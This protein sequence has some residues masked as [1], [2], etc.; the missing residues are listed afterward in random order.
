[1][2]Y[3]SALT[4][5]LVSLAACG[6]PSTPTPE[7]ISGDSEPPP[8]AADAAP[9]CAEVIDHV[10]AH[11]PELVGKADDDVRA[12]AV[13]QCEQE[14]WPDDL[15]RCAVAAREMEALVACL[16]KDQRGDEPDPSS[17]EAER[18]L[19]AIEKGA[20]SFFFEDSKFPVGSVTLSP[21]RSCCESADGKCPPDPAVW[22]QPIWEDLN[23]QIDEAHLY[24]YSYQSDGKTLL[25][26]AEADLDC[27]GV[28]STYRLEGAV[29]GGEPFFSFTLTRP[30]QAE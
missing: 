20:K 28:V 23:F 11:F 1:M 13:A 25:V 26:I 4:A 17:N 10:I 29:T 30:T 15:K 16:A 6:G 19:A 27:D 12:N 14:P 5:A 9:S 3:R 7:P 8:R 21:P 22:Q 24:R 2:S 18:N